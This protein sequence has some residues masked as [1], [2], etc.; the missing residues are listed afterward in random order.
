M[1]ENLWPYPYRMGGIFSKYHRKPGARTGASM[2]IRTTTVEGPAEP[3]FRAKPEN[4]S[5]LPPLGLL[6]SRLFH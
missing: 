2:G 4:P 6:H 3:Q 5:L 1:G